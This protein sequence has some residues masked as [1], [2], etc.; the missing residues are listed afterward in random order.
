MSCIRW[1]FA[2]ACLIVGIAHAD[3]Q[4]VVIDVS[5]GNKIA[6]IM[7]HH[8]EQAMANGDISGARLALQKA[9]DWGLAEATRCLAQTYDPIWLRKHEIMNVEQFADPVTAATLYQ[10]AAKLGDAIAA[11]TLKD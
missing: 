9:A 10:K 11:N 5:N 8:G 2:T 4:R 1:G 7:M 3:D 6:S